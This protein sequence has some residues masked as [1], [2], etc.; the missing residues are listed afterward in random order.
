MIEEIKVRWRKEDEDH[1]P[2]LSMRDIHREVT[3]ELTLPQYGNGY[4]YFRPVI[5][6]DEDGPVDFS[7][8]LHPELAG[9]M[10]MFCGAIRRTLAKA[11]LA[12]R[13]HPDAAIRFCV[14]PLMV[15]ATGIETEYP[16]REE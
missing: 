16:W 7:K 15:L 4:E 2:V 3:L 6:N 5:Q 12:D 14:P 8:S 13:I 1:I 9:W 11:E 10:L